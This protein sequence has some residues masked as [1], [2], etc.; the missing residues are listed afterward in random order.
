MTGDHQPT[1]AELRALGQALA[2]GGRAA[3][4]SSNNGLARAAWRRKMERLV[5]AG[6]MRPYVHGG[7][8]LTAAG[9]AAAAGN[10]PK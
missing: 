2:Q 7:Y 9:E 4:P 1:A 10:S 6:L 3:R 5:A 8:E